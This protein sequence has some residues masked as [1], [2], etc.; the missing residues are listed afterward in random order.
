VIRSR[1][2]VLDSSAVLNIPSEVPLITTL[3]AP[4]DGKLSCF[5]SLFL[6]RGLLLLFLLLL[7]LG[8]ALLGL[9]GGVV[10]VPE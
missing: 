5:P 7:L 4:C 1:D 10:D 6:S 8:G 2:L 3:P 9:H